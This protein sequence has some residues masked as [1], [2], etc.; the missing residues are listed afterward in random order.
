MA[1]ICVTRVQRYVSRIVTTLCVGTVACGGSTAVGPSPISV[2]QPAAP[3]TARGPNTAPSIAVLEPSV[4]VV[5]Q[6]AR[7]YDLTLELVETTGKSGATILSLTLTD[8]RKNS[9][10]GGGIVYAR[11]GYVKPGGYWNID[12]LSYCAPTVPT[13][14]LITELLVEVTYADDQDNIG[15]LRAYAK[16]DW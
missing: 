9:D 2:S 11:F 13:W 8:D 7:G 15:S 10:V 14:E 16:L 6:A 3:P 4:F 5:R 12:Q 1:A